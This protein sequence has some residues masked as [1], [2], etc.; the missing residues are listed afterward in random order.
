MNYGNR[1]LLVLTILTSTTVLTSCI[2]GI[3]KYG[4]NAVESPVVKLEAVKSRD[5]LDILT[6]GSSRC[7]AVSPKAGCIAV[8]KRNTARIKFQLHRSGGWYFTEFKI[9]VG[10]A[11]ASQ[12]CNLETWQ[13]AEFLATDMQA[14]VQLFPDATGVIDL[15][16]L[17]APLTKFY[18]YDYN[19]VK[20]DYFY[21]IKACR[22]ES[23]CVD[24]DPPIQNGGRR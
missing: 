16:Q 14:S 19:T 23:D 10:K 6:P 17:P 20:E 7:R 4:H 13:Q 18:L 8:G 2:P 5:E 1:L 15:T 21:S 3:V 24:T 12:D 11:K 9:C 22:S